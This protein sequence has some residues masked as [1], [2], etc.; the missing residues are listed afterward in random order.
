LS[1]APRCWQDEIEPDLAGA[2]RWMPGFVCIAV[3]L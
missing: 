2:A 1:K 3:I